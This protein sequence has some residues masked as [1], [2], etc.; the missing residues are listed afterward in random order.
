MGLVQIQKEEKHI[1]SIH[2]SDLIG[3]HPVWAC[4]HDHG[5]GQPH[6]MWDK[7]TKVFYNREKTWNVLLFDSFL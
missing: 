4:V 3:R 5:Q 2:V 6:E 1:L 7:E